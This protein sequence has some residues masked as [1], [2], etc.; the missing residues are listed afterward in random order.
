MERAALLERLEAEMERLS[1][2]PDI[3]QRIIRHYELM[4]QHYLGRPLFYKSIL[5]YDRFMV[6]LSLLA[7]YYCEPFPSLSRVKE[8]CER[9]G[10][11]SKNSLESYFA[12]FLISG[13]MDVSDHPDDRRLRI[14]KPSA[15]AMT[16][17]VKII[18]AYYFPALGIIDESSLERRVDEPTV[19]HSF[20]NFQKVLDANFTLEMLVPESRWLMN[21]DGGHMVMLAL[22]CDALQTQSLTGTGRKVSTYAQ[23]SSRLSVS[24]THLIRMVK[25]GEKAG[26]FKVC[27]N[28]VEITDSFMALARRMMIANFAITLVN[29]GNGEGEH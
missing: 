12:F 27:K 24:S 13:Y 11:L 3:D 29:I 1:A 22:F 17:T 4:E 20:R 9:R 16:E 28:A 19:R 26:Y 25:E 6:A 15:R 18:S 7:H 21:R 14:Y 23:L 8:F 10:Y 5:K 2:C